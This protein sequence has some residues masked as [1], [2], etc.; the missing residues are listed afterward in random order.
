MKAAVLRRVGGPLAIEE[1]AKPEPKESE[2]LIKVAACGVC[3]SDLHLVK[4]HTSFPLPVV[5]GHEV[6]G[7]VEKIVGRGTGP[8]VGDRVVCTVIM[9]CGFCR[10]CID[11]H[12]DLC[13]TFYFLNRLKGVLYDGTTRIFDYSGQPIWMFSMGGMAEY[14]VVPFNAVFPL[15][16]GIQ[17]GDACVLG[18]AGLTAYGAVKNQAQLRP[19]QSVAI[20]GVGGVG[21]SIIQM[22]KIF[23]AAEIIAVDVVQEKLDAA[24]L[25][26]ATNVVNATKEETAKMILELTGGRGV[27]VAFEATGRPETYSAALNSVRSG[28]TVVAVGLSSSSTTVPVELNKFVRKGIKLLGSYGARPRQDMPEV[29]ELVRKRILDTSRSV[30]RRYQLQQVNEAL[31]ALG[32]GEVVGRSILEF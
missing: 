22:A 24:K 19:S 27:D 13:E 14:A 23:G 1:V 12:E 2:V 3:H 18:C 10:Y 30:T 8:N 25:S 7:V 16:D 9:P 32:R 4:G 6:S 11:G 15:P 26:G 28:G 31:A 20:I 5:L 21:S 29:L 17:M